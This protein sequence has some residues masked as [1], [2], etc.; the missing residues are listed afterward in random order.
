MIENLGSVFLVTPDFL[1]ATPHISALVPDHE[2]L[3]QDLR[4][5]FSAGHSAERAG[6]FEQAVKRERAAQR[7][8]D[9]PKIGKDFRGWALDKA[10]R[11]LFHYIPYI[12]PQGTK[13]RRSP[14]RAPL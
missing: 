8:K 14:K 1:Q 11:I 12:F 2:S 4:P 10:I 5:D 13:K 3:C 9:G 7:D 6:I